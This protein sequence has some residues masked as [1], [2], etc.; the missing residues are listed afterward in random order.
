MPNTPALIQA[1]VTGWFAGEG[2]SS[3]EKIGM[4]ELLSSCGYAFE[5][6]EEDHLD[7][8][9]AISGA[10]PGFFYA[11]LEAWIAAMKDLPMDEEKKQTAL[12]RTLM[13]SLL[14][15][16][17]SEKPLSELREMVTSRGG[18]TAAGLEELKKGELELVFRKM[19]EA[20]VRR[21][22][23]LSGKTHG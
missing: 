9:T 3:D 16:N 20:A 11:V 17:T 23:E 14:L 8:V 10:G 15:A 4:N 21:A 2:M 5:V 6:T 1:G 18:T 22:R 19:L 12:M 7:I 13:G